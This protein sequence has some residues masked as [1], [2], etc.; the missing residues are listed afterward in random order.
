ME[1]ELGDL[2]RRFFESLDLQYTPTWNPSC[3]PVPQ[4]IPPPPPGYLFSPVIR[5]TSSDAAP[6]PIPVVACTIFALAALLIF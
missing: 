3:A 2:Q 1:S 5:S 6:S 4:T